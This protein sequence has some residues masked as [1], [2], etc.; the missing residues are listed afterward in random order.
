MEIHTRDCKVVGRARINMKVKNFLLTEERAIIYKGYALLSDLHLGFD[1]SFLETGA[2]FPT[3]QKDTIFNKILEIVEK[4]K[5]KTLILNG[6]IKHNFIPIEKEIRLVKDF[7]ASLEEYADL[8]LIRGNHDT[9]LT[10]IFEVHEYFKLGKYIICHGDKKLEEEGFFIIGHEHPSIKLRDEV[11]AIYKFPTYLIG[12]EII[13]L[14]N[15][16]PLSPGNDLINNYPSSPMLKKSYE[17]LEAIAITE[18]GLLNFGKI[19]ELKRVIF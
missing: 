8:I 9:Y 5:V 4:Y 15:F 7:I 18:A 2:N 11:G 19:G 3:F 1:I 17:E 10:K 6:D 16:N 14:P 12:K 13:V